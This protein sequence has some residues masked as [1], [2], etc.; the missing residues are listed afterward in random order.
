M[1]L[2]LFQQSG[3]WFDLVSCLRIPSP[4]GETFRAS[5]T[6][7]YNWGDRHPRDHS[8]QELSQWLMQHGGID[9]AHAALLEVFAERAASGVAY[10]HP[11]RLGKRKQGALGASVVTQGV[12][13]RSL[14]EHVQRQQLDSDL[15]KATVT[16][17]TTSSSIVMDDPT[18][19]D[20]VVESRPSPTP[21]DLDNNMDTC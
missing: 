19:P 1:V 10:N 7:A 11:A 16:A 6:E 3:R 9:I 15:D 4:T 13:K 8:E 18:F 5:V 21:Y 14:V 2:T 12:A 17:V 20:E